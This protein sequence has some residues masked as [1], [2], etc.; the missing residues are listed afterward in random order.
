[1]IT[2]QPTSYMT[3][4]EVATHICAYLG[5]TTANKY[6]EQVSRFLMLSINQY[7]LHLFPKISSTKI[8]VDDNNTAGLHSDFVAMSRLGICCG[9]KIRPLGLNNNLCIPPK[10]EFT[11]ECCDCDKVLGDGGELD[12]EKSKCCS[13]CSVPSTHGGEFGYPRYYYDYHYGRSPKAFKNGEYRIDR[14]NWQLIFSAGC[15]TN[16]GDELM[17]EY[18]SS[19]NSEDYM[20]IPQAAYFSL[21]FRVA[22]F[23]R[24][25]LGEK[26]YE[27]RRFQVEWRL[28]KRTINRYTLEDYV[29][30]VRG[31]YKSSPKR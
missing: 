10:N 27:H 25:G 31:S 18:N 4:E 7:N 6:Y 12:T 5:D 1:M 24:K 26:D 3:F 19:N 23:L 2:N 13:I 9:D 14:E 17:M 22:S 11:L 28:L 30:A 16:P 29:A 8:I 15:A 20:R 21:Q